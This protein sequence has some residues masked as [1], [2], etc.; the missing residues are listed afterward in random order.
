MQKYKMP[1]SR[2]R[3]M[4]CLIGMLLPMCMFAQQITVQGIVKDQT[5]ETVI[6][7]SVMEKGT[8]NGTIT[9]IDGD[10][11][12][13]MS[14]NGTLVVS[15]V[16]Y[17]TQE[18][19]VKGQKQLQ[20]VLSED[21]EML[22][23]VVVIGYGTMKKSDLTGAVSSIGNKDIKDSPVSNLGQA[24]QGKISGVQ[25]V[26]AG[27]PGDNV[28]IKIR[29]LGSINNCDPL[30]VIDGV[31][32]DLGLSSLNMADVER[33]DVLKD[34]SATAIYG[35]RGANG[36]VM[37][38]TKRGTEG[39]GKLAVSANYSFQ[40]ATNVP[41][42][43]NAAQYAEL[44][45]DMMVNSGRNPNPEW[46]NPSE[47]GAGTDWMDELLRTGVMQN[48]TVSYS[49]GNEKSHYYVSGGFLDQSGIVKSVNYRRFT[50]QSNSD[51]QVL[52]WLKFSNNI[53]FSADTK[54]SGSYNIG[55][56][57]KALPIYPVKNEDGSWSGPDGN[58]EWYGSTRNPI[59]PT[60]LNKSQTDGYNFLANLTAELTFT[61]WLKFKSTFGY[62]A[63][64]WFIDNFTPKYNW[65]PTPTEETSRYKSD[66]K[67]F[68]YLWDN[69]FL[70]DHTFAEKHRVG[71]MAGMS[72]QW[73]TNDYL[74]AQKNV[75]MFDNV[76][77]MDNGEKM[78]AIGGNETEWA[79]LSYMARVNYSY[80]DRY[81]LTATIRRDGS[82]RFGK[83][84]RWGTFPSVSVAWRAS[85]EKWFPKNDYINDLKVRAGYGVTG[86]Q[87]SVGNYSYLASYNTSVYPFGISSGN[88]TALVSSTLA[89]PYIHWEEVAQT[90]IGFDASLFN[91]R[92]MF[93]FDAYLKETRDMLV[94][95]SI[96]ITSG[97]EDTTTT[98]TNAGKVRNQ[99]IE[100]SLHTI[101]LTGE[102]G[103]ETNVTATYN[104][105]KIKDLNSD[106]PYYINQINNS[107]VTMLAKD[108][109]INVFYGYVTDGIFQNQSE[110]NTHAVQPGAEPG[111]IRF[112]DLNNDG[113]INDSD[114]TVIGNPNPSWLFSMNNS[115]SYKGF[116]L[117]VFLQ[118]IAGNKI[119]N[120]N[121]ID[122]TGMAAAYNQ[123]TD[124]LK[125][126]QGEG[127]SNSMP[128]AVFGDP[129]QNTR[130]SD[131]FVENGSYLRLK[132][133]T[134]SYTFPKQWL[135]KAQIENARL[136][137][138][139]E[140]VATITGYSGFD[141]EVG[142]NGID[143]NRYPISRTFSLGLNFNF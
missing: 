24:I 35:S 82:S 61:K 34:A 62:D 140:N 36:V 113:V 59:G 132:N 85:Q 78:Y 104:K 44:S 70:F 56:A 31:P 94:K 65:K 86:S 18:V 119:Y 90:N 79:L 97:F 115:L 75:F 95:A 4:V 116:E 124:V 120:A 102:L 88:Q 21:A 73:N 103:W 114:R 55:D 32:T 122:N 12:L 27:K 71:L 9:G 81:L 99:G 42:L 101:N 29:G 57:L 77:E 46:A 19:Q 11:S 123:T 40:N 22:D 45:N 117:S 138:S 3:M 37:I 137:L 30:V 16:G 125:R 68:T 66:N 92:V 39:K 108:Y 23:E 74:N 50:F 127:T 13:N 26:D 105:N 1:I 41:S 80:E 91:S 10:F 87:A 133:I 51:A 17:K 67:S 2:L 28:S 38:T 107:Y 5:G 126:W 54:K 64:F 25:I 49:G 43:L 136:S 98:Y 76:H 131:R 72:A 47:L 93:S 130:V 15:F 118:G 6:G 52:K 53:T 83:K 110:V 58:S 48:Y 7:A 142:I 33:L 60:E 109:P 106:V 14:S 89:N 20:V 135:Q 129:N 84:H 8:T 121:N 139:C 143:Q 112:R 100:M 63:K 141:P 128:R 69:Y 111:D 96:P 134:L